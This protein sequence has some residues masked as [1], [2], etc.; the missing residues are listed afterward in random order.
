[1][2][3]PVAVGFIENGMSH[4]S[5]I[6]ENDERLQLTS[7]QG[8]ETLNNTVRCHKRNVIRSFAKRC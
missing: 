2:G 3:E 4:E 8:P 1:M 6:G 7:I 5:S